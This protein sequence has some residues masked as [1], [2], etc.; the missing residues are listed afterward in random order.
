MKSYAVTF[1]VITVVSAK[2]EDEA[3][4][5]AWKALRSIPENVDVEC[6]YV[7]TEDE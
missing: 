7:V 4:H 1:N 3:E 5:L 6:L 2:D